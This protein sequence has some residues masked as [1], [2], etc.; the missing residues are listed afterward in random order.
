MPRGNSPAR[1]ER[2]IKR[3][4]GRNPMSGQ[5]SG[6]SKMQT[7]TPETPIP[8][9]SKGFAI[10]RGDFLSS[11]VRGSFIFSYQHQ[12]EKGEDRYDGA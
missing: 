4:N 10:G 5:F 12:I 3:P 8:K 9:E 11:F 6:F 7:V 2:S 1:H